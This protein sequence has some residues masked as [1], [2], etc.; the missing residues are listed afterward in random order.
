MSERP[1]KSLR[2]LTKQRRSDPPKVPP[3]TSP[4]GGGGRSSMPTP[5]T[6]GSM[7]DS[8]VYVGGDRVDSPST[9]A[10]TYRSLHE[11]DD[12][13]AWIGL[14]QPNQHELAS[15]ADEFGLHE[16]AVEDAILAHQRPKIER[17]D[18][19]LFVVL[20]AAWYVDE[21]EDIDFGELH[22]FVGPD[23]VL[24][25]RHGAQPDL[26]PVRR[27]M[28]SNPDLLRLGP[29]AVLYAIL[30][31]V[32][33]GYAPVV[34][35][36]A[37][38]IDEIETEMFRGDTQVSRRIYELSREVVEFQRATRPLLGVVRSLAAGFSKYRTDEELQR[39]LRDVED[40]V[41]GT[42]EQIDEFR[43]LLRDILTVNATLV[44][45]QQNEEMK[46]LSELSVQQNDEVK[47]ISG[48]A[49]IL[50]APTLVGT[51][52]G[53]NFDFMPELQWRY[54]YFMALGLMLT[55]NVVLYILFRRRN[56]I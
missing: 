53:M 29:E 7:I 28:E 36:L 49:A 11:H 10:D 33:D 2:A 21:T 8:A 16:L 54:G 50:F 17:Y 34:A 18:D 46:A 51:V 4:Q 23:F 19:T 14:Y 39:Y 26:S 24:T 43:N 3:T 25:V 1:F 20:R 52:Y 31:R 15:L 30:D 22:L 12:A 44:A 35:G 9:L 6:R 47:K 37:N 5:V 55:V 38:D 41:I 45:Q 56:W 40:H 27:R 48:W 42:V 32:V 13:M